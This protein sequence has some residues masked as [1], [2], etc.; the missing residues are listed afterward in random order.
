MIVD[1]VVLSL[2]NGE[3]QVQKRGEKGRLQ[4]TRPAV[5][6]ALDARTGK[7]LYNSGNSIGSWIHF[8]GLAV[9]KIFLVDHDSNAYG[10]GVRA[11][12]AE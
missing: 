11:K 4:N 5:L 6:K 2:F 9:A 3:N 8:S 7:E 1:E 12:D 10:F